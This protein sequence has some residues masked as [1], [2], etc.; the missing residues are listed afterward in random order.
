MIDFQDVKSCVSIVDG[1]K[2]L[3]LPIEGENGRFR[4]ACPACASEDKRSLAVSA[5]RNAFYCFKNQR[6]GDVIALVA[7]VKNIS[8]RAAAE[9]LAHHFLAQAPAQEAPAEG[10]QPLKNLDYEH[11]ALKSLNLTKDQAEKLGIGW[12]NKGLMRGF[13]AVPIR[14]P[15][16]KLVGYIGVRDCKPPPWRL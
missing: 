10:L 16:G 6:G 11:E 15:T 8:Q 14:L 5:D 1:A 12:C 7:H 3:N 4:C 13:V 2:F 9:E